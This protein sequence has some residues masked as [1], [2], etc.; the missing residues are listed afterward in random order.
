[1]V[2][3]LRVY[4]VGQSCSVL[5]LGQDSCNEQLAGSLIRM[6]VMVTP[7]TSDLATATLVKLRQLLLAI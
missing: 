2:G 4:I 1:M 6:V 3:V 5:S 7:V